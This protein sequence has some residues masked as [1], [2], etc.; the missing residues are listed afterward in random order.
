MSSKARDLLKLSGIIAAAFSLGL[1]LASALNIPRPGIAES[2]RPLS[3]IISRGTGGASR[4]DAAFSFADVVERVNPSVVYIQVGQHAPRQRM[5][6]P[7]EFQD[8][9]RRFQQQGPQN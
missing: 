2:R 7:P 9:F 6:V 4:R 1:T 8:F 3:A 5:D